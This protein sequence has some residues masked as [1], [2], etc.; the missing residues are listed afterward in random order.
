MIKSI[1]DILVNL[2][3]WGRKLNEDK[4]APDVKASKIAQDQIDIQNKAE[5][6]I[7]NKNEKEISNLL[8]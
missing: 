3:S 6:A 5:K 2:L 4:N 1:L 7:K 8:S